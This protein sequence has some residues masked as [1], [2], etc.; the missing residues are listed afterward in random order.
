MILE[1]R[2]QDSDEIVDVEFNSVGLKRLAVSLANLTI[3]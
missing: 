2:I 1:S 3:I